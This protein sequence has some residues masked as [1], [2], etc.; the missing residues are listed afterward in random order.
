MARSITTI[1]SDIIAEKNKR[2]ELKE[3]NSD[4]RVSIYNGWAYIVATSIHIFEVIHDAFKTDINSTLNNRIN[5]TPQYYIN[6]SYEYQDGDTL[7]VMNDGLKVGYEAEDLNKRIITRASYEET[8]IDPESHDKLLV[9]KVSK[10]VNGE[11]EP[12]E[13]SELL[14]FKSYLEKIKFAGTNINPVSKKGD[15]I[16][17]RISVFHNGLLP[18]SDIRANVNAA[19]Y[20]FMKSLPFDSALYESKLF[21]AIAEVEN[22]TDVYIDPTAMPAQGVFMRSYSEGGELEPE[23]SIGRFKIPSAGYLRESSKDGDELEVDNF[24]DAIIIKAE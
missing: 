3:F 24:D 23:V 18:E 6:K 1:Q 22:V 19:I 5:G 4:S 9:I 14:R 8:V 11:L 16:I 2:L 7:T 10:G 17:P 20:E 21:D 13:A 15:V 12:L